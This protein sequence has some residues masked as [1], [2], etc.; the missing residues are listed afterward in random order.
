MGTEQT[1]RRDAHVGRSRPEKARHLHEVLVQ[2]LRMEMLDKVTRVGE[3]NLS[4]RQRVRRTVAKQRS[5]SRMSLHRTE[6]PR[7]SFDDEGSHALLIGSPPGDRAIAGAH[8]EHRLA[9]V[10][11]PLDE[12][13]LQLDFLLARLERR[14]KMGEL[15]EKLIVQLAVETPTLPGGCRAKTSGEVSLDIE[16]TRLLGRRP[17]RTQAL[18]QF[19]PASI[20]ETR[21]PKKQPRIES[22][23]SAERSMK[24]PRHRVVASSGVAARRAACEARSFSRRSSGSHHE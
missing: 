24:G 6:S 1:I 4:W 21:E 11:E 19:D 17:A 3:L 18:L 22:T 8:F 15:R 2:I 23:G 10:N 16:L 12:A 20:A 14:A 9:F 13:K 7:R 5:E